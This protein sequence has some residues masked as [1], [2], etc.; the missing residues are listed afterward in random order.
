ME[1]KISGNGLTVGWFNKST[2]QK[3]T[4]LAY[5][6]MSLQI[7]TLF[8]FLFVLFINSHIFSNILLLLKGHVLLQ[9]SL[10]SLCQWFPLK[11]ILKRTVN[12]LQCLKFSSW[13]KWKKKKWIPD[14]TV[15]ISD[16]VTAWV[17]PIISQLTSGGSPDWL[18][19]SQTAQLDNVN[20]L[21]PLK[22]NTSHYWLAKVKGHL[23]PTF[24]LFPVFVIQ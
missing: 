3:R 23:E 24:S 4:G 1:V 14:V 21:L 16:E 19:F 7:G 18:Y 22:W 12:W 8:L 6:T 9:T 17:Y 10:Q 11:I 2:A 15:V 5:T 13:R 20:K